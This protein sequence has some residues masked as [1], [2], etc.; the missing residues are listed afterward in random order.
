MGSLAV[1]ADLL[2]TVDAQR[3]VRLLRADAAPFHDLARGRVRQLAGDLDVQLQEPLQRHVGREAL[4]ALVGD[5]VLGTTLRT[6][7]LPL[8]VI[9]EAVHARLHAERVLAW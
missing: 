4:H 2:L 1:G 7:H 5:A 6:F 8:H 9:D 3:A